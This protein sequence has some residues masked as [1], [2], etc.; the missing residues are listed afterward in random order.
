MS[1]R[2]ELCLAC[3]DTTG[4]AGRTDDSIFIDTETMGGSLG[5]LC[6]TCN[7]E[8]TRY[9]EME[10]LAEEN[11][12]LKDDLKDAKGLLEHLSLRGLDHRE[13]VSTL[14][15]HV[16]HCDEV[17]DGDG[18]CSCAHAIG[19]ALAGIRH[20]LK[21]EIESRPPPEP[22]EV[23]PD[24]IQDVD[25]RH[26]K[27]IL[28]DPDEIDSGDRDAEDAAAFREHAHDLVMK[29]KQLHAANLDYNERLR[30]AVRV[31]L[32]INHGVPWHKVTDVSVESCCDS[33]AELRRQFEEDGE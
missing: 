2:R 6:E 31:Q 21:L 3:G 32:G 30:D 20:D 11:E 18:L 5:P 33:A 13:Q 17:P 28:A 4:R 19:E 26:T 1:D 23:L 14:I 7:R 12:E 9:E 16:K 15:E 29:I 8:A 10:N 25:D 22:A 24:W 27:S